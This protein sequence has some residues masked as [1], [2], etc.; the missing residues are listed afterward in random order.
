MTKKEPLAIHDRE[1][2]EK[3]LDEKQTELATLRFQAAHKAL[4]QVDKI[5][6]VKREIAR[7]LTALHTQ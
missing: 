4:R 6:K 3:M 7:L 2:L 1:T 5:K